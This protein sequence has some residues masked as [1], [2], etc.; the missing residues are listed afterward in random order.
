MRYYRLQKRLVLYQGFRYPKRV[1]LNP[2]NHCGHLNVRMRFVDPLLLRM[3]KYTAGVM[4][5]IF[6]FLMLQMDHSY[7]NFQH[8][9]E[10]L[11]NQQFLKIIFILDLKIRKC[12]V[13]LPGLAKNYGLFQRMVRLGAQ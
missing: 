4:I 11:E 12:I 6:T 9:V 3:E 5:T 1:N 13:F 10:L 8:M 7:G 2:L